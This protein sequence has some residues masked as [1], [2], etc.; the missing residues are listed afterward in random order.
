MV[1]CNESNIIFQQHLCKLGQLR[2]SNGRNSQVLGRRR[3]QLATTRSIH[4]SRGETLHLL[5]EGSCIVEIR[6]LRESEHCFVNCTRIGFKGHAS[7]REIKMASLTVENTR[8]EKHQLTTR[9]ELNREVRPPLESVQNTSVFL[10][11]QVIALLARAR[12]T[13]GKRHASVDIVTTEL[14]RDCQLLRAE[15]QQ[16]WPLPSRV[17]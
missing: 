3:D 6:Q 10:S 9:E 2:R 7:A 5:P 1:G 12:R 17:T 15:L 8:T 14:R 16:V 4:T 11:L 13:V